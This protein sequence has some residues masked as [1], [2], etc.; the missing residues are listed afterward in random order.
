MTQT[1]KAWMQV[2]DVENKA[3][4]YRVRASIEDMT[5]VSAIEGGNFSIGCLEDGERL[6]QS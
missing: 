3:P 2:E 4:F 6:Y 1:A 5:V